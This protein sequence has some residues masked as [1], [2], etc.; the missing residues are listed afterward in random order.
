MR[1][2]YLIV[3][4]GFA[5]CVL[6]E[7]LASQLDKRILLIDRRAHIGGNAYDSYNQDGILIHNY[8]P[9]L[10]HTNNQIV[11]RYLSQFT[12]WRSYEHRVLASI[13]GKLY[14]IPIN[15][16]TINSFYDI[17]LQT[18]EEVKLFLANKRES[19]PIIRNSEDVIVSQVGREMFE[20][21]FRGYTKKQ[22][23]REPHELSSGVCGRIPIRATT[24]DRYFN[25]S[26][27][28]IPKDGYTELFGK[29]LRYPNIE[30][31]QNTDYLSVANS[32]N[33][34]RLIYT[35]PIDEFFDYVHGKLPYRSM[36]FDHLT[37]D[38]E[39]YQPAAQI[40]YCDEAIEYTRVSEWKYITGQ[41]HHKTAITREFPMI[42]G[43]PYYPIPT[44]ENRK[45]FECYKRDCHRLRNVIFVGRLAEYQYYN[46]DQVVARTLKVFDLIAEGRL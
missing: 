24:D 26:F 36:K 27:Q 34:D 19:L 31:I 23:Q 22:W 42:D 16:T 9:H 4:A 35:G 21:F 7:R 46:M 18:E 1:Y 5:G 12:D 10:F 40:N 38:E 41:I 3:G 25:D 17:D 8:G 30:F 13:N 11:V 44:E 32:I 39:V 14:P 43:D 45:V 2:D 33:F 37:I 6:A 29:M 20:K 15:Q 28:A